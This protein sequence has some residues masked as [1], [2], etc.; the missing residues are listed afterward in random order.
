MGSALSAIVLLLIV[1]IA[2]IIL[3][4]CCVSWTKNKD[5]FVKNETVL[6]MDA[7]QKIGCDEKMDKANENYYSQ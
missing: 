6:E 4:V 5:R 1:F 7:M 2:V 3:F